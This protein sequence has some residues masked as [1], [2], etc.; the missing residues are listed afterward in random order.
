MILKTRCTYNFIEIRLANND[1]TIWKDD[2][3]DIEKAIENL[4]E[5]ADQ[6]KSYL[7]KEKEAGK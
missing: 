7:E 3:D 6:L 1:I 5:V 4:E 2:Q